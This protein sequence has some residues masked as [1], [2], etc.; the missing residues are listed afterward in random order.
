MLYK[1]TG[2][3]IAK[4]GGRVAVEAGGVAFELNL[5]LDSYA[6]TPKV[7]E[8]CSFFTHFILREDSAAIFGFNT[9]KEKSLFLLLI[10][11]SKVGPKL[12]LAI[13]GNIE[14]NDLLAAIGSKDAVR[15][16]MVPG[17]GK[18]TAERIILEIA[19]KLPSHLQLPKTPLD[20]VIDAIA[21]LGYKQSDAQKAVE[22]LGNEDF[23]S[24]LRKA[25]KRLNG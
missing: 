22:G 18:K 25:L 6:K 24:I 3:L 7:G 1:I 5:P 2:T 17:V 19:D 12:A 14:Y 11:V 20:D 13:L 23:E 15:L 21:N 10:S 4:E 16:S 8:T 9:L